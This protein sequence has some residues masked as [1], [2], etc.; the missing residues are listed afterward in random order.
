[1]L[2]RRSAHDG[3]ARLSDSDGRTLRNSGL[4]GVRSEGS[5]SGLRSLSGMLN[6]RSA[7]DGGVKAQ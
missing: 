1:M 3:G 4:S 2:N 6:R 5:G 7:H